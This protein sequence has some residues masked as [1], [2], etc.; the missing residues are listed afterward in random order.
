M[1]ELLSVLL[2]AP[3]PSGYER[4][5][6]R[7]WRA[8]AEGFAD[9]VWG[10]VHGNSFAEL[11]PDARP[12][13]ML[14]G[15]I[16]EIGLMVHH[17]D[18]DGYLYM[19][20]VGGWDPQVL[21]GQRVQILTADGP[22][23]GVIGWKAIHLIDRD[24]REKA[25][26]L[27]DL[28]IDIGAEDGEEARQRVAIGDVAVIRSDALELSNGRISARSIDDRIGALVVL[29]ALRRAAEKG[30]SAHTVAV[31]TTQEE[32]SYKSGGGARTS[33]FGLEPDAA[34]VVDVTHATDHPSV[35][36]KEHGD[37]ELG[38]GPVLTRGAV[39]NR[40]LYERLV[41]AAE[42]AG[43][44]FQVLAS[45]SSTGTDA[46]SIYTS[47]AGVATAIVSVPDRYMHTPNQMV[48]LRD[49]ENAAELI[50]EMLAGLGPD[51]SFVPD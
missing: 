46:D 1:S 42:E 45:P 44:P 13:V 21:V 47:R 43:L 5:A 51:T 36:K 49:V 38:E 24:D 50:A 35:D 11:E 32:I 31:A 3:G 4:A 2:D 22:I 28:W 41:A 18:D 27:K 15:H 17:I 40:V 23:T 16:D 10:D 9:R 7:A 26:K 29:E 12:R 37:I 20:G 8:E 34:V 39:A 25:V 48:A 14:A 19:Q 6:A 30:V 33:T